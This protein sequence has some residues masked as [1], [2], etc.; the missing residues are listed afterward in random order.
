LRV[1]INDGALN[2][3]NMKHV[4]IVALGTG[5]AIIEYDVLPPDLGAAIISAAREHDVNHYPWMSREAK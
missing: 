4:T 2:A 1:K 3:E 5:Y